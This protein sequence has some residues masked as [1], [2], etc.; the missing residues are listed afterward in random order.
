MN[1]TKHHREPCFH[2]TMAMELEYLRKE[3]NLESVTL[4]LYQT[5]GCFTCPGE[6]SNCLS[7]E[8]PQV[9]VFYRIK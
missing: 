3:H 6:K 1:K 8:V 9:N 7:F 2:Y 5:R 4:K